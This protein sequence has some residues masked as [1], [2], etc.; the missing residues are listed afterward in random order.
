MLANER[1]EV[2]KA[3]AWERMEAKQNSKSGQQ[4]ESFVTSSYIKQLEI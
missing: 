4:T 2:E 1:R 3:A